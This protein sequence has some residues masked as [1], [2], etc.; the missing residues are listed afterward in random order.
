M[1][2]RS[3]AAELVEVAV[4]VGHAEFGVDG[5]AEP[6][7][8]LSTAPVATKAAISTSNRRRNSERVR[9]AHSFQFVFSVAKGGVAAGGCRRSKE[10][11]V[12]RT[13]TTL[14][15]G[16]DSRTAPLMMPT[17]E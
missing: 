14:S 12:Q 7:A 2:V 13:H 11:P 3:C 8:Q 1:T 4:E 5:S 10:M 16:A 17:I 6:M 15:H 9:M